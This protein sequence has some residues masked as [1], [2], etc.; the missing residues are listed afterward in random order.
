MINIVTILAMLKLG[1]YAP[2][3]DAPLGAWFYISANL[4]EPIS[5]S[6]DKLGVELGWTKEPR[7]EYFQFGTLTGKKL[8]SKDAFFM[9]LSYKFNGDFDVAGGMRQVDGRLLPYGSMSLK[10]ASLRVARK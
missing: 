8:S 7:S 5:T 4:I 1:M 9:G 2:A 6:K 3:Q 10:L